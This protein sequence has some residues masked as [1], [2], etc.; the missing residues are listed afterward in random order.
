M[1]LDQTQGRG[2]FGRLAAK[3]TVKPINF[4]CEAPEA[5][6]VFI[7]GDFND[8]SLTATPMKRGFD[9][10]WSVQIPLPH[11]HHRYVLVIDGELA[12]D[13]RASGISKNEDDSVVS[14]L[15][16]S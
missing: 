9:G 12:L 13:P 7:A 16:V 11:G 4:F 3:K 6:A 1:F 2:G 8:W 10:N 14:L 5:K 15:S